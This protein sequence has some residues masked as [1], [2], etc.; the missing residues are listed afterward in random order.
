MIRVRIAT[1]FAFLT[2]LAL[3]FFMSVIYFATVRSMNENFFTDLE[4]KARLEAQVR[5]EKDEL[6]A[7]IYQEIIS[8]HLVRL[9]RENSQVIALRDTS[10]V[11]SAGVLSK[12]R[13][14]DL[15]NGKLYK[16]SS[17]SLSTVG[18]YY[19]DNE[20]N[21]IIL[22]SA[23][24]ERGIR[25]LAGLKQNMGLGL[26]VTVLIQFL[27]GF[28]FANKITFPL[29][30]MTEQ[31][32]R[33]SAS[34]LSGRVQTGKKKDELNNL[35]VA[36]N[37]MLNRLE[38]GFELQRR[39]TSHASH[40]LKTPL[41]IIISTAEITLRKLRSVEDY[42]ANLSSILEE[43]ERLRETLSNLIQL[44]EVSSG[45]SD[46]FVKKIVV[47]EELVM[48]VQVRATQVFNENRLKV[49]VGERQGTGLL[50][51]KVEWLEI[52]LFN[53][54]KNA[55]KFSEEEITIS[56]D[57]LLDDNGVWWLTIII[58]DKGIG[59]PRTEL[60]RVS[61]PF[62]RASNVQHQQGS[63][64][65]LSIVSHIAKLH[66]G[67]LIIESEENK[68]TRCSLKLPLS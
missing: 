59:I 51:G 20:G 68:G 37:S 62:F 35:A 29:V 36:I 44:M 40:E 67:A 58:S 4:A 3:A 7:E 50:Y 47:I 43:G 9:P 45:G 64:I 2:G 34:D 11:I 26:I 31:L 23:V 25:E 39:F 17:D 10:Q 14:D 24:N 16:H 49:D 60:D 33:V 55:I 21:F 57:Y 19:E 15:L 53:L 8:R 22:T 66:D 18:L 41:T 38:N 61:E 46:T 54:I 42:K 28:L 52:A 5:L 27:V 12:Q 1:L 6:A 48:R 13:V 65:G 30:L 32:N 56:A 63:G